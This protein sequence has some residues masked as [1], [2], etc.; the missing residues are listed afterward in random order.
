MAKTK[1]NGYWF[2]R[3]LDE[4]GV[5][6]V[7]EFERLVIEPEVADDLRRLAK[8]AAER[9]I[10]SSDEVTAGSENSI[11]AGMDMDLSGLHS[12]PS[13]G[14]RII[15][16]E[17]LFRRAWFYFDRIIV[18]DFLSSHLADPPESRGENPIALVDDVRILLHLR[19][20]G[21]EDIVSFCPKTAR[22][23]R[24]EAGEL[25][26]A[27]G[28]PDF[29]RQ[30]DQLV[31]EVADQISFKGFEEMPDGVVAASFSHPFIPWKWGVVLPK[32]HDE[33]P[34]RF[35]S[36][37]LVDICLSR[38]VI[39]LSVAR[40]IKA[41]LGSTDPLYH[42]F[43]LSSPAALR[44]PDIAFNLNLP[45]LH[46]IPIETLLKIRLDESGHFERFRDSL[47]RAL[48]EQLK[49]QP[50]RRTI[51]LANEITRDVIEPELRQI[52]RRLK[53][54]DSALQRKTGISL[55]VGALLTTCGLLTGFAPAAVLGIGTMAGGLVVPAQQY[56]DKRADVEL[57]DMFFLWKAMQHV[58]ESSQH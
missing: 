22:L 23:A 40:C 24:S 25:L 18:A 57:S 10:D 33:D 46:K 11:L 21:A 29:V 1:V 42:R 52:R 44:A 50:E 47:R 34:S 19:E 17:E 55:G 9:Q 54:A 7:E 30:N 3:W 45:V 26:V 2:Y 39:D 16:V 58:S 6:T 32:E 28:L 4:R 37:W 49:L 15:Q 20:I 38:F 31:E 14:C 56:V 5:E 53:A 51:E 12:C 35:A 48:G 36:Q 13:V 43:M 8:D 41:P 27:A